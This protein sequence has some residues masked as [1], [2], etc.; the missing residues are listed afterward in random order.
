MCMCLGF[1]K[2]GFAVDKWRGTAAIIHPPGSF[3][4]RIGQSEPLCE[5]PLANHE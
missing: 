4:K 2:A 1:T 3:V 5:V